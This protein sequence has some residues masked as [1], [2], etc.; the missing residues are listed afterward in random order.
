MTPMSNPGVIVYRCLRCGALDRIAIRI[1]VA[2]G[3]AFT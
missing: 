1:G 2:L 3:R